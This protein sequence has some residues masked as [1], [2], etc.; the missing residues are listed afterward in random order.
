MN[1]SVLAL[2]EPFPQVL[3]DA[4]GKDPQGYRY[5][6]PTIPMGLSLQQMIWQQLR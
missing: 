3:A 6:S 4:A 2:G 5:E 1:T